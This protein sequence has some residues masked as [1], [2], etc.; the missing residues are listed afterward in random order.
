[1]KSALATPARV[2]SVPSGQNGAGGAIHRRL[3]RAGND[4]RVRAARF[5]LVEQKVDGIA[6]LP[7]V[8]LKPVTV[9]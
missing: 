1:L 5:A 3:R 2:I 4:R 7:L 6:A 8:S 9:T